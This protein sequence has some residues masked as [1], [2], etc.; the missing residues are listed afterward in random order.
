MNTHLGIEQS[1]RDD[2]ECLGYVLIYLMK[3][4]LPWQ[5]VKAKTR[6]EKYEIIKEMKLKTPIKDLVKMKI[7][8][9]A[10]A[11]P[12]QQAGMVPFGITVPGVIEDNVPEEFV[13]FMDYCRDLKFE[14][15]PDYTYLRR[16]FKDLFNRNG[17]EYDYMYDWTYQGK[18]K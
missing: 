7:D 14:E 9:K 6:N 16:L 4:G 17:Y 1:R 10:K 15:K 3:G 5:G 2:L 18:K 12:Q 8:T 13:M 11:P